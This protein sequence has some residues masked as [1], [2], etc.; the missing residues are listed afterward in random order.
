MLR[1]WV[2]GVPEG[3]QSSLAEDLLD[4]FSLEPSEGLD[5]ELLGSHMAKL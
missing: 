3:Y 1:E 4:A 5:V 2:V